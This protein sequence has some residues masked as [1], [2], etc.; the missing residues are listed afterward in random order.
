MSPRLFSAICRQLMLLSAI[1]ICSKLSCSVYRAMPFLVVTQMRPFESQNTQL[2]RLSGIEYGSS[3]QKYWSMLSPLHLFS[4]RCVPIQMNPS[5]SSAT[6][7]MRMLVSSLLILTSVGSVLVS[8]LDEHERQ[9]ARSDVR[10]I[11]NIANL[12]I[13]MEELIVSLCLLCW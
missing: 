5:W 12:I 4:P 6:L 3:L 11:T 9:A 8:L 10:H 7:M 1:G 13:L 2:M